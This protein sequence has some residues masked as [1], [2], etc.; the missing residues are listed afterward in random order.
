MHDRQVYA[1]KIPFVRVTRDRENLEN[2]EKWGSFDEQGKL[3]EFQLMSGNLWKI[4]L[5]I[6]P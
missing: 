2:K 5:E 1:I 4:E 6:F 3:M